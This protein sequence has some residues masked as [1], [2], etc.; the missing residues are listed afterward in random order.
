MFRLSVTRII[1]SASGY[2]T[3]IRYFISSAQSIAV[4]KRSIERLPLFGIKNANLFCN[5][6]WIKM[7][8][9]YNNMLYGEKIISYLTGDQL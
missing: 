7:G 3:S 4:R 5:H 8:K 2:R 9:S 6:P 1:F